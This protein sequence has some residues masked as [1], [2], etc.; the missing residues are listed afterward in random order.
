MAVDS[1]VPR[2]RDARMTFSARLI[3]ATCCLLLAACPP[4]A[5]TPV[6]LRT[7]HPYVAAAAQEDAAILG[8]AG[9]PSTSVG[10]VLFDPI[11]GKVLREH[12]AD[13]VFIPASVSKLAT[14]IAALE[15]LGADY[16]FHTQ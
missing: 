1:L 2:R 12:N 14:A 5:A 10:F 4:P 13:Q 7:V 16:T 3:L 9:V 6:L 11:A 15:V 8:A